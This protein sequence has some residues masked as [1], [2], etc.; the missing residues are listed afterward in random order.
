VHGAAE[1]RFRIIGKSYLLGDENPNR[2][3]LTGVEV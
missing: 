2:I 3:R 1:L